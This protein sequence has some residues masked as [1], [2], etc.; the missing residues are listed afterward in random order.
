ME[1]LDAKTDRELL[2]M[3]ALEIQGIRR[4]MLTDHERLVIVENKIDKVESV[5][6]QQRGMATTLR[7]LWAIP[8]VIAGAIVGYFSK[9]S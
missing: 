3:T 1:L 6:D 5:L 9:L 8:G 2:L 7:F 4:D